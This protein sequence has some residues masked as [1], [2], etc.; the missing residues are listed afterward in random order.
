MCDF[1]TD[2]DFGGSKSGLRDLCLGVSNLLYIV[3]QLKI[4]QINICIIKKV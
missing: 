1:S 3:C 2:L 4:V